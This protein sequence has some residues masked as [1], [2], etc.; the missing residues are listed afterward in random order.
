M[1]QEER[2]V[3]G[4]DVFDKN[5]TDVSMNDFNLMWKVD[6]FRDEMLSFICHLANLLKESSIRCRIQFMSG[7]KFEIT[8]WAFVRCHWWE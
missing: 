8:W 4:G 2:G 5:K 7:N 1:G 3:K 6:T